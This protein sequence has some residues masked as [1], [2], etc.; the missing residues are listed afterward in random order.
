[1]KKKPEPVRTINLKLLPTPQ[2]DLLLE[3]YVEDSMYVHDRAVNAYIES[4]TTKYIGKKGSMC[5]FI[6]K[7]QRAALKDVLTAEGIFPGNRTHFTSVLGK[8]G[9]PKYYLTQIKR[10]KSKIRYQDKIIQK[11]ESSKPDLLKPE[12]IWFNPVNQVES[13]RCC[14]CGTENDLHHQSNEKK[15]AHEVLCD[16]CFEDYKD[17]RKSLRELKRC[18]EMGYLLYPVIVNESECSEALKKLARSVM[19][20][21][22]RPE[23]ASGEKTMAFVCPVLTQSNKAFNW[24][25]IIKKIDFEKK[26]ISIKIQ[27]EVEEIRFNGE[28]YYVNFPK[29]GFKVE[30]NKFLRLIHDHININKGNSWILRGVLP[31]GKKEYFLS[32]PVHYHV[33][34]MGFPVGGVVIVSN[35]SI[36]IHGCGKSRFIKLRNYYLRKTVARQCVSKIKS[37]NEQ[38]M[39]ESK[40]PVPIPKKYS[41][42]NLHNYIRFQNHL[43]SRKTVQFIKKLP[44]GNR[45]S[46]L[47]IDYTGIHATSEKAK[48]GYNKV[49]VPISELNEQIKHK[50]I[51]DGMY[52]GEIKWT[53]LKS[54]LKCPQCD[55]PLPEKGEG[56]RRLVIRDILISNINFWKCEKCNYSVNPLI[57]LA[58]NMLC[59]EGDAV[60]EKTN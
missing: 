20:K 23:Y 6:T 13:G 27:K 21:M 12:S 11:I 24:E 38:L 31:E 19:E 14:M 1:M 44:K 4:G 46:V 58:E 55:A 34:D 28:H 8:H 17:Y 45:K 48:G 36:L 32:V 40:K 50:L 56:N 41:G 2:Q 42:G 52:A 51:Y 59:F 60:A 25:N 7:E 26:I 33:P 29:Y 54:V 22:S 18:G 3:K 53:K 39:K 57:M 49:T 37:K 16:V 5:D 15:Y 30:D 9:A 35:R 10:M 47:L 43:L